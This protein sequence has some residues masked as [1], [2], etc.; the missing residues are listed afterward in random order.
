MLF[1]GMAGI[2]ALGCSSNDA[3]PAP[4]SP[5]LSP[6]LGDA[7][8]DSDP[9]ANPD[10]DAPPQPMCDEY[11]SKVMAACTGTFGQTGSKA[12]FAS[13][14]GCQNMCNAIGSGDFT[15]M[16]G[17]DSLGCRLNQLAPGGAGCNAA[18]PTGG[19]V[20]NSQDDAGDQGRCATFCQ[21]ATSLC[22][23]DNGVSPPPFADMN[24]CLAQ[25]GTK[26]LFDP[27]KPEMTPSGNTLNCRQ[28]YLVLAYEVD[29][30]GMS[31]AAPYQCPHLGWPATAFCE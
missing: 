9:N 30:A 24:T 27:S 26:F 20:C 31:S 10:D 19:G 6:V 13:M 16:A 25:C 22:T 1:A 14:N 18:G 4:G 3:A 8:D 28:Y 12:Q 7:A 2:A 17:T 15:D 5:I 29:D 21:L 23:P 11:C